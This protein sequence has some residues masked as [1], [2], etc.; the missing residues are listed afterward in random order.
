[1]NDR[2]KQIDE[3]AKVMCEEY[4]TDICKH[5]CPTATDCANILIAR[6]L[7]AAGYRKQSDTAREFVDKLKS[8]GSKPLAWEYGEGYMDCIKNAVSIAK[9]YD[10]EVEE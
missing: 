4:N 3:M 10:V 8:A 5:E 2:E 7:I 9:Q 6:R 1:M